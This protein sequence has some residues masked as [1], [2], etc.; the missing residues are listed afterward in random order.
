MKWEEKEEKKAKKKPKDIIYKG[1]RLAVINRFH[2]PIKP[3]A[4]IVVDS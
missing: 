3:L 1:R 4:T 2:L